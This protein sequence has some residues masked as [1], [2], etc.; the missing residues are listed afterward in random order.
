MEK[1]E[2]YKVQLIL[3]VQWGDMDAARHVNNII[4]LRW[5]ESCRIE[6]MKA[7]SG[8]QEM[9]FDQVGPILGWQDCKYIFPITYPDTALLGMKTAE[10]KED[11]I[12]VEGRVFSQKAG[13]LSAIS[14]QTIIAY[15]YQNLTKA[16]I[17]EQWLENIKVHGF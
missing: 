17:P 16:N 13:R 15:D 14:R 8:E 9:D 7:I 10:I 11:R 5:F 6:Y 12:I 3:P 2:D 1:F 4:Y